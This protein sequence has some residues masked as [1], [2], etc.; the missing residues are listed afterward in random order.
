MGLYTFEVLDVDGNP[1]GE[2]L[3]EIYK[4]DKVP[5][6]I[7]SSHGRVA[8]RKGV[9]V[10]AKI[11]D[12]SKFGING[13]YNRGLGCTVTSWKDYEATMAARGL[14]READCGAHYFEESLE[15]S[16]NHII[17]EEKATDK[18]MEALKTSGLT[19]EKEDSIEWLKAA[20]RYWDIILPAEE[21]WDKM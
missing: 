11:T 5:S 3:E 17:A 14:V 19:N 13:V 2:T 21:V 15:R 20:E 7:T 8:R 12:T 18:H 9:E 6:M 4:W 10:I 16:A 1:T